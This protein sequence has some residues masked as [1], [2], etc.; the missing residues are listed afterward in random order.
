MNSISQD[1]ITVGRYRVSPLTQHTEAGD[2]APSV[3]I[4]SG[5]GRATH[6]RILR[7]VARFDTREGASR[8]AL[9]QGLLW[10]RE[11]MQPT[12]LH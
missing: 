2:Y 4:R 7:F 5:Q 8:Y 3:S 9:E 12:P 11:R 6:D 1:A 10:L